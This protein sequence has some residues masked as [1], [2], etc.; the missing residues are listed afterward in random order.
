MKH[1][2]KLLKVIHLMS[3]AVF[4]GSIITYIFISAMIENASINDINAGRKII[5]EGTGG[6][7]MPALWLMIFTGVISGIKKFGFRSRLFQI[8]TAF[9]A[10]LLINAYLFIIPAVNEATEIALQSAEILPAEYYTAYMKESVFGAVNVIITVA[11]MILAVW[12]NDRLQ[13]SK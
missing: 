2:F 1:I 11:V 6:L 9:A 5:A 13:M 3:L 12:K 7:T 4:I 8:K 10:A